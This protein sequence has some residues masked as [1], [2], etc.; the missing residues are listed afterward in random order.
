MVFEDSWLLY[1]DLYVG[2]KY[3]GLFTLNFS[4]NLWTVSANDD[5]WS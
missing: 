2:R 1:L 5:A 4:S 3:V